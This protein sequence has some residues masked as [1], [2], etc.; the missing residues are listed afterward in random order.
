VTPTAWTT[1]AW[2][3]GDSDDDHRRRS[4][5]VEAG[6]AP[7]RQGRADRRGRGRPAWSSACP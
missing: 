6:L 2:C 5:N 4:L 1:R 7:D 3:R